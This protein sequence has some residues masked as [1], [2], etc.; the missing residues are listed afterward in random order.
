MEIYVF[1]ALLFMYIITT[2]AGN[3]LFVR[4]IW[5]TAFIGAAFLTSGAL[6]ALRIRHQDV[7]LTADNFNW[8]FFLYLTG[9]SFYTYSADLRLPS[10]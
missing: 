10:G 8:Y 9:I 2:I 5:T 1:A 7:M 6:L 4:R 3:T